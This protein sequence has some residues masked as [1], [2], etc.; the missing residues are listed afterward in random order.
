MPGFSL[1]L[2]LL[3]R[4]GE[5]YSQAQ[6][7][8]YLDAPADAPGWRWYA[9]SVPKEVKTAEHEVEKAV[10]ETTIMSRKC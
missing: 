1:T 2:L 7:L 3:P 9:K 4:E 5:A 10:E 6:I 8:E